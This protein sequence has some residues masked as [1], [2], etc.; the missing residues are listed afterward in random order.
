[1]ADYNSDLATDYLASPPDRLDANLDGG[2]MRLKR[3]VFTY[4]SEAALNETV[5]FFRLPKG[6]RVLYCRCIAES[7]G[8]TGQLDIG[9]DAGVNSL[10][11]ADADGFFAGATIDTGAGAVDQVLDDASAGFM[12]EF[13]DEVR[14]IANHI[15]AT[16]ASDT[17]TVELIIYYV[18]GG[19]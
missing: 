9:W 1:M 18:G 2:V 16:T 12:K 19:S 6:A 17:N 11:T 14:V 13:A 8:T 10:E 4:S 7:D 15:E 3:A 5:E